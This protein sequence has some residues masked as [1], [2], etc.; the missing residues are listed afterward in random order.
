MQGLRAKKLEV[1]ESGA[2]KRGAAKPNPPG[3]AALVMCL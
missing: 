1:V 2:A 3:V